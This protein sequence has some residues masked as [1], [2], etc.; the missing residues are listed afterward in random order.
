MLDFDGVIVDTEPLHMAGFVEVLS[1]QGIEISTSQYFERYAGYDDRDGFTTIMRDNGI[2]LSPDQLEKM[3]AQKTRIV[4]KRISQSVE[5][6][7]GVVDLIRAAS[8]QGIPMAICSGALRAEIEL[9]ATVVGIRDC[10]PIVVSADDVARGKPDPEGYYKAR[11]LLAEH[12][13]QI[14]EPSRCVVC[15][16]TPAGIAAAKGAEMNVCA[17]CTSHGQGEL[18]AA[19]MIAVDFT[20]VT[21]DSLKKLVPGK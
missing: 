4:Q 14:V 16:D 18:T 2:D 9:A 19:D 12:F 6:I 7:P 3:I 21:L 15:E 10:F 5:A 11:R 17:V 8:T 1:P 20:E 13:K